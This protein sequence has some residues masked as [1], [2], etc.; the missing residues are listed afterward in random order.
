MLQYI[1]NVITPFVSRTRHLLG[2]DYDQAFMGIFDNFNG[3]LTLKVMER[4]EYYNVQS[5]IVPACCTDRLQPLDISVNKAA[6]S[7]LQEVV[8]RQDT[9]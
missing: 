7:F 2:K 6:R 4:L 1:D 5:V 8:C 3:Q 9:T